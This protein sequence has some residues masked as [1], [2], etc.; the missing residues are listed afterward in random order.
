M[1]IKYLEEFL[2]LTELKNSCAAAEIL[3][4]SPSTLA[5]HMQAL[6]EEVG[7]PLF[8][9]SKKGYILNDQGRIFAAGA[10]K[11]ILAQEQCFS[12]LHGL[13]EEAK[14]VR[15]CSQGRI[16]QLLIDFQR[17][18]PDYRIECH[19]PN[20]YLEELRAGRAEIAFVSDMLPLSP[21]L[22]C[23]PYYREEVLVLVNECHPLAK[24]NA[25]S[26][27]ELRGEKIISLWDDLI[28]DDAFTELF[29]RSG[30]VPNPAVTVTAVDDLI[31][32]VCEKIGIAL[33]H[34]VEEKIPAYSGVC[35]LPL[36]PH[37]YYDMMMC[38]RKE[39]EL[40]GAAKCF[41]SFARD[42]IGQHR[43]LNPWVYG[44]G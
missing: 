29:H 24:Q 20:R 18:C 34:G 21:E 5:R 6:E 31:Q 28:C 19:R 43:E 12:I 26:L 30:F 41:L 22:A 23:M 44:V 15:L 1:E 14:V 9:H 40:S 17:A 33:I 8:D 3:C 16:I 42:W 27:E 4:V 10:R 25:V 38:Y 2:V 35:C 32:M 13:E 36:E 11:I 39:A 7:T 37:L